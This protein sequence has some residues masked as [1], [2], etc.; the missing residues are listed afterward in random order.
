MEET[1]NQSNKFLQI[2]LLVLAFGA[3]I[4]A[5]KFWYDTRSAVDDLDAPDEISVPEGDASEE[6]LSSEEETTDAGA[7]VEPE[8]A[9]GEQTGSEEEAGLLPEAD[10]EMIRQAF[11]EKYEKTPE[12]QEDVSVE[13]QDVSENGLYATGGVVLGTTPGDAGMFWVYKEDGDW[14][15]AADGNGSPDC[16]V[17]EDAGF[18]ED[19]QEGCY[20][21]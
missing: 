7:A 15:I 9:D 16:A 11:I 17:L 8:E 19:M 20:Y 3:G 14:V 2:V 10:V 18:P 1:N 4:A 6:D 12:E 21:Y 13:V 5:A